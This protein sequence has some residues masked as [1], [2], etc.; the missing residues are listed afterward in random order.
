G[1]KGCQETQWAMEF[2]LRRA[3]G[4]WAQ[5]VDH[6]RLLPATQHLPERTVGSLTD[7]TATRALQMQLHHSHRIELI[8]RLAGGVAHDFNN[9]LSAIGGFTDLVLADTP[10]SDPRS[11]DL[12]EISALVRRAT[13][14]TQNL[15]GLSRRRDQAKPIVLDVADGVA[16][17]AP[18]LRTLLGSGVSLAIESMAPALCVR[19]DAGHFDQ[20]LLNLAVN[21]R[22]AMPDGGEVTIRAER[23][24]DV[25]GEHCARCTDTVRI[26][27]SDRG[28]G[29]P[30][31]VLERIF[32]PYFT[33]KP[34]GHGTG[35]GL[36]VVNDIVQAAGGTIRVTSN[37]ADGTTFT[38]RLPIVPENATPPSNEA[39]VQ[40]GS[41]AGIRVL[42]IEDE[43]AVRRATRRVLERDGFTVLEA[44]TGDAGLATLLANREETDV[45]L[46][47][48]YMPGLSGPALVERMRTD[49]PEIGCVVISGHAERFA[50]LTADSD[51]LV[52]LTKPCRPPILIGHLLEQARRTRGRRR[53]TGAPVEHQPR[54]GNE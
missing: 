22:D 21:A 43:E 2:R 37:P 12:H 40:A 28:L 19:I 8:G 24:H 3:D 18:T 52:V 30:P 17:L 39:V 53:A 49:A 45:I 27:V 35:L 38:V 33:T 23:E 42:F 26:D 7:I 1:I 6:G 41:G 9:V 31:E 36:A 20:I 5:V 50:A 13:A 14:L 16:Q 32:Q 51:R 47:D 4:S 44:R 11:A 10:S 46:T 29:I 25:S 34:E 15:L 48:L 54:H